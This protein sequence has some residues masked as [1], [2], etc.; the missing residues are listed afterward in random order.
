M[1]QE[2]EVKFLD[3]NPQ[4]IEAKLK[5]IGAEKVADYFYRRKVFDFPGWVMDKRGAWIR[6]RDE[7]DRITLT[8]KQRL[9][10]KAH[11]GSASDEGMEEIEVVVS[12]FHKTEQILLQTGLVEKTYMENKRS[13]WKK[14]G[15]EFDL[16]YWPQVPP[17]LEIEAA[18]WE[19]VN[20]GVKALGLD[21]AKQKIFSTNQIYKIY[22]INELEYQRMT[23]TEMV[24]RVGE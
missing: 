24:K 14:D 4:E 20:E 16:D 7:G 17:Y 21:P 10:I 5:Q 11:D 9:G 23:F 6:L 8:Y 1:S 3:I 13:R 22:G 19:K 18:N 15:V 12:D 2:F